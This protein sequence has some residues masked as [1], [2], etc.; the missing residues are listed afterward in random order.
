MS[1]IYALGVPSLLGYILWRYRTRL[2][3]WKSLQERAENTEQL[4]KLRYRADENG[5]FRQS[6]FIDNVDDSNSTVKGEWTLDLEEVYDLSVR[7]KQL[8]SYVKRAIAGYELKYCWFELFEMFRKLALVGFSVIFE[9]GGLNQMVYGLLVSFV[10]SCVYMHCS[11]YEDHGDDRL[12][13]LCQLQ[14]FFVLVAAVALKD[15]AELMTSGVDITLNVLTVAP[16]VMAVLLETPLPRLLGKLSMVTN[17]AAA[18]AIEPDAERRTLAQNRRSM[19]THDRHSKKFR[20]SAASAAR[21]SAQLQEVTKEPEEPRGDASDSERAEFDHEEP[22][23]KRVP[24][25]RSTPEQSR[26]P[27]G[28]R[29]TDRGTAARGTR[30]QLRIDHENEKIRTSIAGT[31]EHARRQELVRRRRSHLDDAEPAMQRN[32]MPPPN[33]LPAPVGWK[34]EAKGITQ[35][36]R[37]GIGSSPPALVDGADESVAGRNDRPQLSQRPP[38]MSHR[39][40]YELGT[41]P[42]S[43]S[44]PAG[45]TPSQVA[46]ITA[47]RQRL[48]QRKQSIEAHA[49]AGELPGGMLSSRTV[50]APGGHT[51]RSQAP[52]DD[53]MKARPETRRNLQMVRHDLKQEA[54]AGFRR[55]R[56]N[57]LINRLASTIKGSMSL[58]VEPSQELGKGASPTPVQPEPSPSRQKSRRQSLFNSRQSIAGGA[59]PST[60]AEARKVE[61]DSIEGSK[62]SSNREGSKRSDGHSGRGRTSGRETPSPGDGRSPNNSRSPARGID[63]VNDVAAASAHAASARLEAATTRLEAVVVRQL[64]DRINALDQA[65]NVDLDGDGTVAGGGATVRVPGSPAGAVSRRASCST[66][67]AIGIAVEVPIAEASTRTEDIGIGVGPDVATHG[68]GENSPAPTASPSLRLATTAI[69]GAH[70][71]PHLVDV[72]SASLSELPLLSEGEATMESRAVNFL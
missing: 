12:A 4:L 54:T 63:E 37:P 5:I 32:W 38:P 13:Q 57:S 20:S 49:K 69:R 55:E 19:A 33:R 62:R 21:C 26:Q 6:N 72:G 28:H 39:A 43:A 44:C 15:R 60:R 7:D 27:A 18:D 30:V 22:P 56:R 42:A 9:P 10:S 25:F 46:K 14:I 64:E 48:V 67:P 51:A 65:S 59:R 40:K 71:E 29:P 41:S 3:H 23:W 8:P 1:I 50:P 52:M 45:A 70:D 61:E 35:R 17:N 24:K 11:P 36:A 34:P 53:G 58:A 68:R 16:F 2:L 31:A 66:I 47:A